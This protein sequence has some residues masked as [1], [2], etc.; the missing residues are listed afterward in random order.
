MISYLMYYIPTLS[1]AKQN[2]RLQFGYHQNAVDK[3]VNI[4]VFR[5]SKRTYLTL[6]LR[7]Q[8]GL[9]ELAKRIVLLPNTLIQEHRS[10]PTLLILLQQ[11]LLPLPQPKRS[12]NSITDPKIHICIYNLSRGDS[13][14]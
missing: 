14:K 12:K 8:N 2:I 7:P 3:Q 1:A 9:I 4:Q 10:L 5:Q 13:R 11:R 6:T